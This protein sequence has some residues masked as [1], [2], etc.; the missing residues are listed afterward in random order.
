MGEEES[1][2][3]STMSEE[4]GKLPVLSPEAD[5]LVEKEKKES[6]DAN[7]TFQDDVIDTVKL[8]VPLFIAMLSW[9]G[10]SATVAAEARSKPTHPDP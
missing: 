8:G 2:A 3:A 7:A 10:V 9:V 6:D 5:P 1:F 4:E